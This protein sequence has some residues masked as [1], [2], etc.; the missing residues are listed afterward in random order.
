MSEEKLRSFLV[1][2]LHFVCKGTEVLDKKGPSSLSPR[3]FV[4][5]DETRAKVI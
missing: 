5:V 4:A 2:L 1:Q 3:E